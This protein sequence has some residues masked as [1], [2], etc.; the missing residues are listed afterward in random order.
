MPLGV[1]AVLGLLLAAG[2]LVFVGFVAPDNGV[3]ASSLQQGIGLAA[4][5]AAVPVAMLLRTVDQS[6]GVALGGA[7]ILAGL[8]TMFGGNLVGL[9]MAILGVAILL[10]SAS[11][12]PHLT[13]G[14][15]VRLVGYGIL[16]GAALWLSLGESTL[17]RVLVAV[18]LP[19]IVATSS[20]WDQPS[21]A[22]Q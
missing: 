8:S 3:D 16:L 1:L 15:V 6:R 18:G 19:A 4:A 11:Q 10:E 2:I 22:G 7:M 14:L 13:L 21:S 17:L 12:Q 20:I 5:V 9:L